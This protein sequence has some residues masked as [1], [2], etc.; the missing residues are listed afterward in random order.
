MDSLFDTEEVKLKIKNLDFLYLLSAKNNEFYKALSENL[1]LNTWNAGYFEN[2]II[3]SNLTN[4]NDN[5]E[6]V[7]HNL[8]TNA[9]NFESFFYFFLIFFIFIINYFY[10]FNFIFLINFF[11]FIFILF[12]NFLI[13]FL[14]L[15]IFVFL[16]YFIFYYRNCN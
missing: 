10:F 11:N 13:Y 12:F 8:K 5:K 3:S 15:F 9:F 16:F 7:T 6:I 1:N 4:K 14:I 2:E